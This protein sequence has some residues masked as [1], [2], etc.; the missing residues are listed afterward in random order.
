MSIGGLRARASARPRGVS[1]LSRCSWTNLLALALLVIRSPGANADALSPAP[2]ARNQ[3]NAVYDSRR[4]RVVLFGGSSSLSCTLNEV[5]ALSFDGTP[6]WTHLAPLG[7]PPAPR[8]AAGA[9]YDSLG[10]R[11]LVFGGSAGCQFNPQNDVWELSFSDLTWR[12]LQTSGVPPAP[13]TGFVALDTRRNRLLV[14]GGLDAIGTFRSDTWALTLDATPTWSE[15]VPADPL[16][17]PVGRNGHSVLYDPI[18]DRLLVLDG[19]SGF[20]RLN[21]G[22]WALSLDASPQWRNLQAIGGVQPPG[23]T[24]Q[25]WVRDP[26][27]D[28]ALLFG[29]NDGASFRSDC[30]SVSIGDSAATWTLLSTGDESPGERVDHAAAFDAD[31]DQMVVVSGFGASNVLLPDSWVLLKPDSPE[32]APLSP[33]LRTSAALDTTR[34]R[35]TVGDTTAVQVRIRNVGLIPLTIFGVSRPGDLRVS[36]PGSIEV[37]ARGSVDL[38]LEFY[39]IS[40]GRRAASI[41]VESDD[42]FS[43]IARLPLLLDGIDLA[44]RAS[45]VSASPT[46]PIGQALVLIVTPESQGERLESGTLVFAPGQQAPDSTTLIPEGD[47]FVGVI[48]AAAVTESGLSYYVRVDNSGHHGWWPTGAP[49]STQSAGIGLPGNILALARVRSTLGFLAGD[50]IQIAATIPLGVSIESARVRYRQTGQGA[51]LA[52]TLAV[53]SLGALA[54][55]I[56]GSAAGP[57]GIEWW[58]EVNTQRHRLTFPVD[59]PDERPIV[60]RTTILSEAE[61]GPHP[62]RQ[63]RMLSLPFDFSADTSAK[64]GDL[65]SASFGPYGVD[66]WRAFRYLRGGPVEWSPAHASDFRL[67]PGRAYWLISADAHQVKLSRLSLST[68]GAESTLVLE[69]GWNQIADP[70]DF[71][72]D[73]STVRRPSTIGALK[74]YESGTTYADSVVMRPFDGYFVLNPDAVQVPIVIPPVEWTPGT[75]APRIANPAEV[76]AGDWTVRLTAKAPEA[77]AD[78]ASF[79]VRGLAQD[80]VDALDSPKPPGPPGAWARVGFVPAA[81]NGGEWLYDADLRAPAEGHVWNVEVTSQNEGEPVTLSLAREGPLPDGLRF[82]LEDPALG[83]ADDLS[84]D[85]G[86]VIRVVSRGSTPRRLRLLAGTPGWFAQR[87]VGAMDAPSR[88]ELEPSAPNPVRAGAATTIRFGLPQTARVTVEVFDL[89]G[90]RSAILA[91]DE[92]FAAGRHSI[93]WDGRRGNGRALPTGV[94][95]IRAE[96]GGARLTSRVMLIR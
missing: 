34:L 95:F 74:H 66:R 92:S 8:G 68:A 55:R 47:A 69:P 29:G 81:G 44:V 62:R 14:F 35:V 21:D 22:I 32:W 59:R 43:G 42:P 27:R 57:R 4:H 86:Q 41:G 2:S 88:F 26:G 83:T 51:F 39:P 46:V 67:L 10:D 37:P 84:A 87:E 13:R 71:P 1:S 24:G 80:G 58:V 31:H 9:V 3:S 61:P 45:I 11:M 30:W 78:G 56:P 73:W 53:D 82:R 79:G 16:T 50:D 54:G 25:T 63:Y 94:Y 33:A 64:L 38:G 7:A 15:I 19:F 76:S 60:T 12:Q 91:H 72:V 6:Q 65:L 20:F 85:R 28:R 40:P 48:P 18:S 90:N 36:P 5:W 52:D 96:I 75:V 77:A 70:F 93:V 23:R 49:E 89:A 17:A